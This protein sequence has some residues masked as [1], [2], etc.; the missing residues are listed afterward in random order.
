MRPTYFSAAQEDEQSVVEQWEAVQKKAERGADTPAVGSI[1]IG[2]TALCLYCTCESQG[3]IFLFC[4]G[5]IVLWRLCQEGT[6]PSC[7]LSAISLLFMYLYFIS[8]SQSLPKMGVLINPLHLQMIALFIVIVLYSGQVLNCSNCSGFMSHVFSP[9][10]SVLYGY[11]IL[12]IL[13]L[14]PYC[15]YCFFLFFT[16]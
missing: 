1:L 5:N 2:K 7:L 6:P 11:G 9:W 16:A 15:A 10:W 14:H 12:L 8:S 3:P 13:H 4:F